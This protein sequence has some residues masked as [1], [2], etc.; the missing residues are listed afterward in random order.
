[1]LL[2]G[3]TVEPLTVAEAKAFLRVTHD[4][5]DALIGALI[6]AAGAQTRALARR[7][8]L[9][10]RRG[11]VCGRW[12]E[13]QRKTWRIGPLRALLAARVF[14][15]AGVAHPV[16]PSIFVLDAS[17]DRLI[18]PLAPPLPGRCNAGIELVA[19]LGFGSDPS[20]VPEPLRHA[21]RTLVAHWYDH[22][23]LIAS[24]G[25]VALLPA[26]VATLIASYRGLA[27]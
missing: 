14:D 13:E 22:R 18:A 9:V 1:M 2:Q 23:G 6:A 10:H 12:P 27:L 4:A 11:L 17:S 26:G 16:D 24:G 21:L 5:D 7:A 3:P 20:E 25:G 8:R 15:S 19:E